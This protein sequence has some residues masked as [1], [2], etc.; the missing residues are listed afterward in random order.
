MTVHAFARAPHRDEPGDA[1]YALLRAHLE[2]RSYAPCRAAAR[3]LELPATMDSPADLSTVAALAVAQTFGMLEAERESAARLL[4]QAGLSGQADAALRR[5]DADTVLIWCTAMAEWCERHGLDREF[6]RLQPQAAIADTDP[7]ASPWWRAHWRAAAAWH[8]EAQGRRAEVD[9]LLDEADAMAERSGDVALRVVVWLHRARLALSRSDPARA[10]SLARRAA[11]H[12]DARDSPLWLADAAD[13]EARA[14][15]MQGDMHRALQHSRRATALAE[16]AQAT[17]S[18]TMTYRL[19]E[20]YA[21][22]GLGGYNDAAALANDLAALAL[23]TFLT[24]R[25]RLLARIYV[26]VRDDRHGPWNAHSQDELKSVVVRL[27]ELDWP[28]VLALLP[29]VMS[30]LWARALDAGIEVDWVRASIRSRDLSP[31]EAAWPSAWPWSVRVSVLGP[32]S[33]LVDGRDLAAG[34]PGKA[35]AKPLALLRRLAVEGG[36]DGVAADVLAQALWP[37]EAREGRDKALET[38]LARLRA[39]L[40]SRDAVLLSER[41]LRLNPQRVWIDS[42]ALIRQLERLQRP[43]RA[44][45]HPIDRDRA[46]EAALG[47]WRGPLLADEPVAPWLEAA[48]ERLRVR[49][50]AAL[51]D[52]SHQRGHRA[53][54]LR[55]IAADPLLERLL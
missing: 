22:L 7:E 14:A 49:V 30:R 53:R 43:A 1:A 20:S 47:L 54:R 26:L 12:A 34:A 19:Y 9:V 24:E 13:V 39:L 2:G 10:L 17:P 6:A 48:R 45:A 46:W 32:F 5:A 23:P 8:Q 35:A 18:Y 50:A 11:Q 55:A 41:R 51:H 42:A 29:Q 3:R 44:G 36:H 21:L 38:T 25:L 33:C 31:P 52:D 4:V 40:G 15:L 37:G 27:R 16:T 28:G